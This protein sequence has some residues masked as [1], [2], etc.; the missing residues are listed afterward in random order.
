MHRRKAGRWLRGHLKT[1]DYD[2][3][4]MFVADLVDQGLLSP[5]TGLLR[6]GH[7]PTQV[8]VGLL[9]GTG[10]ARLAE[11]LTSVAS[12][13]EPEQ[14]LTPGFLANL[15]S[16]WDSLRSESHGLRT[17]SFAE[18]YDLRLGVTCRGALDQNIVRD[19]ERAADRLVQACPPPA[20]LS[21]L[22]ARFEAR[23]GDAAVRL[24]EV[25]DPEGGLL[26]WTVR[27]R[28]AIAD[29]A[30]A[31]V[32]PSSRHPEV[33]PVQLA[34]LDHW[35]ST[36]EP[37]DLA[38]DAVPPP[39]PEVAGREPRRLKAKGV[40]AALVR[41][42]KGAFHSMLTGAGLD[43]A[44]ALFGR[45]AASHHAL[46]ECMRMEIADSHRSPDGASISAEV[47]YSPG[48]R[49][50]NTLIRPRVCSEAIALA[51]ATGGT[52]HPGRLLIRVEG[53]EFGVYDALTGARIRL[54]VGSAYRASLAA[55]DPL[56]VLLA[57]L[58]ESSL[59][60]TWQWGSLRGLRRL[61][62][63]VCGRVIVTPERWVPSKEDLLACT[64]AADPAHRL[65]SCLPG[66]GQRRWIGG[67]EGEGDRVLPV[68]L[69]SPPDQLLERLTY[70]SRRGITEFIEL[71]QV[72]HPYIKGPR[73][74]H[75]TEICASFSSPADD[76]RTAL[77][78]SRTALA[79]GR[80]ALADGRT[81]LADTR[82]VCR[83]VPGDEWSYVQLFC[84]IGAADTVV[85][86]AHALANALRADGS[87]GQ[88][89][90]VRYDDGGYHVRVRVRAS[91]VRERHT[92][93]SALHDLAAALRTEGL[94]TFMRQEPYVP[95]VRRYGGPD[96]I[97][98]AEN[99]FCTDSDSV[100]EYI[101]TQP[102]E[103]QR[104]A[105]AGRT[106]CSWWQH[107]ARRRD[108]L[109]PAM[110]AAQRRLWP[111]GHWPSKG[112][113]RVWRGYQAE[114]TKEMRSL[115]GAR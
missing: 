95:E 11:K 94:I 87:A 57:T 98:A 32:Q 90:F 21:D 22:R 81:A 41:D 19:L 105:V 34:A 63:V 54:Y 48:G 53:G 70:L 47:M 97:A 79:D 93:T 56:Y 9:A 62:R 111:G 84:G 36:G 40:L 77:A 51:G 91:N 66:L 27:C 112:V 45:L 58:A 83:P 16:S 1:A 28:S 30:Q 10:G 68:D 44:G 23:H 52:I 4:E 71:P 35:L 80:T 74:H 2:K 109:Y 7:T 82:A 69:D 43:G 42:P 38:T 49:A 100:A 55:N 76:S 29:L 102:G 6:H 103:V 37:F 78:D 115:G 64:Q 20:R 106:I 24:L 99:L 31:Q 5:D 108:D 107:A 46:A 73:G 110:R 67:R 113:G 33:S 15:D 25:A 85:T 13:I 50:G 26:P 65:R 88:W 59:G 96:A 8:A 14:P 17:V 92:V 104:L 12:V 18:R 60:V 72:E 61:P 39:D 89:F 3:I 75:V 86:R 101:G 114:V